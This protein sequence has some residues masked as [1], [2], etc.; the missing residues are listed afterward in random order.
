M[1]VLGEPTSSAAEASE[2]RLRL[3][4]VREASAAPCG[5]PSCHGAGADDPGDWPAE[6]E[7]ILS[8]L[9]AARVLPT[10]RRG[11][12]RAA[13]RA[14]AELKLFSDERGREPWVLYTRDV[15]PRGMGFIT[16][17]RLPL[18][19]GGILRM[20]GPTGE[21][22]AIDCSVRR[23]RPA[24]NGWF[25]GAMSFNREQWSLG[26]QHVVPREAERP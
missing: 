3:P 17:H 9:D 15:A 13:F 23:C 24:V 4:L 6:A 12:D 20:R 11:A 14:V 22:L 25:E 19:Y 1:P 5:G 16:R 26:T 8:A 7:F 10:D 21:E 18:G 2:R